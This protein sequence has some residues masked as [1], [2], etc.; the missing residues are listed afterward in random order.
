MWMYFTRRAK[1]H[2]RRADE[3]YRGK[4]M[5]LFHSLARRYISDPSF[6]KEHIREH[7]NAFSPFV[8]NCSSGMELFIF[9]WCF[10]DLFVVFAVV[11]VLVYV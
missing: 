10:T 11:N 5:W 1:R 9:R 2:A 8:K 4:L 6:V 3:V 7:H